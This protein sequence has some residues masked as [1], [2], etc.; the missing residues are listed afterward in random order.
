MERFPSFPFIRV[1]VEKVYTDFQTA[2]LTNTINILT[3]PI[4]VHILGI[5]MEVITAFG[6]TATCTL[7]LGKTGTTNAYITAEDA[8]T[9][10]IKNATLGA[11]YSLGKMVYN[12]SITIV[13]KAIAT[14]NNLSL[15]TQGRV[16]FTII[17]TDN[18]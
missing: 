16:R 15:L 17:Y 2:A 1:P 3:L 10:G 5:Q 7:E 4:S 9:T 13:A 14:V 18:T 8:K 6:G 11:S 12:S